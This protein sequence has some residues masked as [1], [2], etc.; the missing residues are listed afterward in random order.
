MYIIFRRPPVATLDPATQVPGPDAA[1][2]GNSPSW[3]GMVG[4]LRTFAQEGQGRSYVVV[5][6]APTTPLGTPLGEPR[7]Q[8]YDVRTAARS[9]WGGQHHVVRPL[10]YLDGSYAAPWV[11][12]AQAWLAPPTTPYDE[13]AP[14]VQ[15]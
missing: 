9:E 10:A 2:I 12:A 14:S 3:G 4:A 15:L 5:D 1:P 11:A 6:L 7:V 8:G 13:P